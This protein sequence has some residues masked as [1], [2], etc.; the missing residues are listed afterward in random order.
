MIG[1]PALG[2]PSNAAA[3]AT[4]GLTNEQRQ[5]RRGI[6]QLATITVAT[7][8]SKITP[9]TSAADGI[10]AAAGGIPAAGWIALAAGLAGFAWLLTR[11]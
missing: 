5:D 3:S 8:G 1:I 9:T 10:G 4:A 11:R 6:W 7:G 2:G